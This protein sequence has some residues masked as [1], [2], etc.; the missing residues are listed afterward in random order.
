MR[1]IGNNTRQGSVYPRAPR[2]TFAPVKRIILLAPALIVLVVLLLFP[3]GYLTDISF[4]ESIPGRM[5]F[6]P[7][8]SLANYVRVLTDSFYLAVLGG[9]VAIAAAVTFVCALLGFPLAY[10]LWRTPPAYKGTLTLLIIAPLLVSVVVRAYGWMIILGDR[11]LINQMLLGLGAV[12]SPIHIMFTSTAMFIGLVHVQ[13]PFMV[14]STLAALERVDPALVQAAET[15]GASRLRAITE[16]VAVLALPGII[17]GTVLVFTLSM[18]AFVTPILLGGS[19]SR[20]MT[21]LIYNEF[22]TAFNWPMGSALALIL[23]VVSLLLVSGFLAG[24]RCI[25]LVKRT[26]SVDRNS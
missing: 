3:L 24:I 14:L 18:T 6:Q 9:T 17:T 2:A 11:G 15:L 26:E 8:Y 20:V 22:S 23:S 13:F 25:P 16:V 12:E 4:K 10:F 7:G 5:V 21:T 19:S 1:E